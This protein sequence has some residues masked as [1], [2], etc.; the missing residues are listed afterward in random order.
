MTQVM[1]TQAMDIYTHTHIYIIYIL[2][3]IYIIHIIY[4][5]YILYLLEVDSIY[6]FNH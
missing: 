5:L 4:I 6:S 3:I 1:I 2:Y